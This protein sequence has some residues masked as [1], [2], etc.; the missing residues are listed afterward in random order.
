[1]KKVFARERSVQLVCC[2]DELI[3]EVDRNSWLRCEPCHCDDI[4]PILQLH[5]VNVDVVNCLIFGHPNPK[6]CLCQ[7]NCEQVLFI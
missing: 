3:T 5:L 4:C 7:L 6:S 1:M 2:T